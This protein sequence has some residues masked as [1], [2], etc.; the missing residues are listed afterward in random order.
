MHCA[1][2]IRT[3]KTQGLEGQIE[4]VG[5]GGTQMEKAG[6]TILENTVRRAAMLHNASTDRIFT[7]SSSRSARS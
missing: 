2:L 3:A 1:N 6:C 7:A 5:V 4:W